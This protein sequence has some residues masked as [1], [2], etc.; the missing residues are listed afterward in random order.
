MVST[1]VTA[2]RTTS[3]C[4]CPFGVVPVSRSGETG[5]I[6]IMDANVHNSRVKHTDI[7]KKTERSWEYPEICCTFALSFQKRF[8]V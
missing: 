6:S 8:G 3:P 5:M 4:N 1:F 2:A 7:T